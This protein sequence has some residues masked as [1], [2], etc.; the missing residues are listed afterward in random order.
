MGLGINLKKVYTCIDQKLHLVVERLKAKRVDENNIIGLGEI[1]INI[2]NSL[3]LI[4]SCAIIIPIYARQKSHIIQ[5]KVLSTTATT[6]ASYIKALVLIH[7]LSLPDN[8]EIFFQL[9]AYPNLNMYAYVLD[10]TNS[11]I[12]IR[13]NFTRHI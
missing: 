10:Y 2:S 11:N 5:C 9:T 4:T 12:I 13:N 3:A 7:H 1:S 8:K 6:F